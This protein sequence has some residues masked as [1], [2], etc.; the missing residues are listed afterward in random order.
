MVLLSLCTHFY[1]RSEEGKK[2]IETIVTGNL[3][4]RGPFSKLLPVSVCVRV[5]VYACMHAKW[6]P[7]KG[8]ICR[9]SFPLS[10]I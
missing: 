9:L 7:T 10:H 3:F 5:C 4:F 2:N 1:Y 8:P 6:H